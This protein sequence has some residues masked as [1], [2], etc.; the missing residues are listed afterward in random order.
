MIEQHLWNAYCSAVV[1]FVDDQ[2]QRHVISPASG[3]TGC[4]IEGSSTQEILII[5]AANP[6]SELISD[7]ANLELERTMKAL[8]DQQGFRYQDC[9]GQSPDGTW[10]ERSI[11][12]FDAPL[13]VIEQIGTDYEQNAIFCWTPNT[14]ECISLVSEQHFVSGW[15][16][17]A[18]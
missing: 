7:E 16:L 15:S 6:Y 1:T 2:H 18:S 3:I 5:S 10:V 4:W 14:W 8:L 9:Q 11:M 17:Q 12:V 13:E